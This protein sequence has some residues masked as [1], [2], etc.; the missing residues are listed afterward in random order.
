MTRKEASELT[1]QNQPKLMGRVK[2]RVIQTGRKIRNFASK[3]KQGI[4]P[5]LTT[6]GEKIKNIGERALN[7]FAAG[8]VFVARFI[9]LAVIISLAIKFATWFVPFTLMV[10]QS[11]AL[12]IIAVIII[13]LMVKVIEDATGYS[14]L[15]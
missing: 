10:L 14:L 6:V 8:T 3:T 7:G 12:I 15:I 5:A 4:K 1:K 13:D 9:G 11:L 2:G